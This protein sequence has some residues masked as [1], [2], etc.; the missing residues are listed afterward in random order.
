MPTTDDASSVP[1]VEAEI[2]TSQARNLYERLRLWEV[3]EAEEP[4]TFA[5]LEAASDEP[6]KTN[7]LLGADIIERTRKCYERQEDGS[8][9]YWEYQLKQ[10]VREFFE[11]YDQHEVRFDDADSSWCHHRVH[12]SN[13]A[14]PGMDCH[15]CDDRRRYPREAVEALLDEDIERARALADGRDSPEVAQ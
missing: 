10:G 4:I 3:L 15:H 1:K 13:P 5:D 2:E 14:G 11:W 9:T 8:K 12:V 7:M 6:N